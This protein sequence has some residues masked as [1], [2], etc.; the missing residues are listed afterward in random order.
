MIRA[1]ASCQRARVRSVGRI[2]RAGAAARTGAAHTELIRGPNLLP[3]TCEGQARP[4][5]RGEV[6]IS[7][8]KAPL[9]RGVTLGEQQWAAV[10]ACP[11]WRMRLAPPAEPRPLLA[12]MLTPL[13]R[14]RRIAAGCP[15]ATPPHW[16]SQWRRG[17]ERC[18]VAWAREP[19]RV[20]V[21]Q[22]IWRRQGR[23][24]GRRARRRH[25]SRP[26]PWWG[27]RHTSESR[28]G[29]W[30]RPGRFRRRAGA[31]RGR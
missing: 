11:C 10:R 17:S 28:P 24:Q 20:A 4:S 14:F 26:R 1:G 13:P 2:R 22:R 15:A 21:P 31:Q 18:C 27:R 8:G 5:P 6:P 19:H 12:P 30:P 29:P 16:R 25:K 23:L 7:S 9:G 3:G